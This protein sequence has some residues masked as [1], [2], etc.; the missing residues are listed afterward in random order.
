MDQENY[1]NSKTLVSEQFI[2]RDGKSAV[3]LLKN[4]ETQDEFAGY[5]YDGKANSAV[6][7]QIES[8]ALNQ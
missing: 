3:E 1:E 2:M 5:Y 7:R 4:K 8:L 6:A